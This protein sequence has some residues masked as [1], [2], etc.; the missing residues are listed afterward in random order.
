MSQT[1][2]AETTFTTWQKTKETF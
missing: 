1:C 2:K